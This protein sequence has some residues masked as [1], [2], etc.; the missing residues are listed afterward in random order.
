MLSKRQLQKASVKM[1]IYRCERL[2]NNDDELKELLYRLEK[3]NKT[4]QWL[5]DC[6][7]NKEKIVIKELI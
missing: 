4:I 5:H 6:I 3:D 1:L 2:K 7:T